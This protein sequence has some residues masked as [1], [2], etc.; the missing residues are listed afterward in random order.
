[1]GSSRRIAS[2][3]ARMTSA[4]RRAPYPLPPFGEGDGA[5]RRMDF[6]LRGQG[7]RLFRSVAIRSTAMVTKAEM[8]VVEVE[9]KQMRSELA[10]LRAQVASLQSEV[11]AL[12]AKG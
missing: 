9:I 5:K 2:A 11:D 4:T 10:A 6:R 3:Y 1:M 7:G 8:T 12:K